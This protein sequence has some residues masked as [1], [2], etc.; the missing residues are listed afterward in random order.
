M[1]EVASDATP[2]LYWWPMPSAHPGPRRRRDWF[3]GFFD[4]AYVQTLRAQSPPRNTRAEVAFVLR[5]LGLP[6]GARILDVAC[7]YGRHAGEFAR[8]GFE[9]VGVDL[10]PHMI[11]EARRR[12]RDVPRLGLVRGDMRRMSFRAEFDAVIS[13]YTS[14]GYFSP[15]ENRATLARMAR[16]L[17]PGGALL[18]DHRDP[19][20]DAALPRRLW[21]RA[22]PRQFI[23]EDRRFDRRTRITDCTQ[24]V[25]TRGRPLLQQK[26]FRIQEFSLAEWRRMLR[27]VG[28]ALV[29]ACAGYDGRP[30]RPGATGRLIVVGRATG[31][32]P[33]PAR[34]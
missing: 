6:V 24:L 12:W 34:R 7:G 13:M 21:Y 5:S 14:F 9:V 27:R 31:I 29:G 19:H 1:P 8:R 33:R 18:I 3:T 4:A 20:H 11:A 25:F 16:A 26:R 28:V 32:R 30:Y 15:A 22:G 17:R 10:S 2:S 23:L